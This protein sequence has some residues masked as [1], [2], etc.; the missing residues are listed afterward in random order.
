VP[1]S[2]RPP[3]SARTAPRPRRTAAEPVSTDPARRRRCRSPAGLPPSD[4][5]AAPALQPTTTTAYEHCRR[6][7]FLLPPTATT[8]PS[9]CIVTLQAK[10]RSILLLA[11]I[12]RTD[13]SSRCGLLLHIPHVTWSVCVCVPG[14]RTDCTKVSGFF[15]K[16]SRF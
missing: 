7:A 1:G 10:Y 3:R 9:L 6:I 12:A 4:R 14:T 15:L 13:S 5:S 16:L 11:G 8:L 2:R